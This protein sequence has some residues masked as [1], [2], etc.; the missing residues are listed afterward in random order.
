MKNIWTT[1]FRATLLVTVSFATHSGLSAQETP[2]RNEIN[3]RT[4]LAPNST[5][6]ISTIAGSVEIET[7]DAQTADI[8]I[9]N[10]APTE[11]DLKCLATPIEE[12]PGKLV[13]RS[14]TVC[15]VSRVSQQMTLRLPRNA[16]L[17]LEMI[18]GHVRI[19]P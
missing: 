5:V 17:D 12:S 11:A 8:N 7:I 16:N 15:Q 2:A 14:K 10:S 6:K 9:V 13:I 18:A 4:Q 1:L 3:R 19:G